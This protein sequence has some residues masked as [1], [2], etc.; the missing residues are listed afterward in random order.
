MTQDPSPET[1]GRAGEL[2]IFE[3]HGFGKRV[4]FQNDAMK[5]ILGAFKAGQTIEPH[6]PDVTLV[7]SILEGDG[8]VRIGDDV[9]SVRAGDVCIIAAG[10]A[11]GV[12][13]GPTGMIGLFVA[14]PLPTAA[15]HDTATPELSWP[16]K[17]ET[18][19]KIG[20]HISEEHLGLRPSIEA[21]GD[22][23]SELGSLEAEQRSEKLSEA[24]AFL[25]GELLPHAEAEEALLYP[26]AELVLRARGGAVRTML[27]EHEAIGELIEDLDRSARA[28]DIAGAVGALWGLR[29]VVLLHLAE[30]EEVYMPALAG[31]SDAEAG[32]IAGHLGLEHD[33]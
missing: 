15:D 16:A 17:Q 31:L 18:G 30:E 23:A 13:A 14:S 6:A 24:L 11:R 21:L 29:S 3:D 7:L 33:H 4:L 9:R 25:K 22:L 20:A 27:L 2:A 8:R 19:R 26:P 32:D 28:D 5:V 10:R 12:E 1:G